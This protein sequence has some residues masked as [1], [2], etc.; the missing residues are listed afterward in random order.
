M[1]LTPAFDSVACS[2]SAMP[3]L[4]IRPWKSGSSF[5]MASCRPSAVAKSGSAGAAMRN[6]SAGS[7]QQAGI[8]LAWARQLLTCWHALKSTNAQNMRPNANII[9]PPQNDPP[10]SLSKLI[11]CLPLQAPFPSIALS[12]F[13]MFSM[14][15]TDCLSLS[16]QQARPVPIRPLPGLT[17]SVTW[18]L[19]RCAAIGWHQWANVISPFPILG[20]PKRPGRR[21]RDLPWSPLFLERLLKNSATPA[22]A[23]ST[24]DLPVLS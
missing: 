1:L 10:S 19:N 7:V 11:T 20:M 22:C 2:I 6:L 15:P 18:T 23:L 21:Q 4:S 12:R 8:H 17:P 3:F 16:G 24:F 14:T 9:Q 5:A 13:I